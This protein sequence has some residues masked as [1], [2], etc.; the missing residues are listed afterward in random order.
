MRALQG[1]GVEFGWVGGE[2]VPNRRTGAVGG[3]CGAEQVIEKWRVGEMGDEQGYECV[4]RG[5]RGVGHVLGTETDEDKTD[6]Q[7]GGEREGIMGT[8]TVRWVVGTTR[9]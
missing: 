7:W 2:S 6:G 8:R 1:C 9:V 4:S 5:T 3:M